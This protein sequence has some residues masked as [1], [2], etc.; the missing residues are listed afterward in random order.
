MYFFVK[1]DVRKANFNTFDA[2]NSIFSHISP[3]FIGVGAPFPHPH[4]SMKAY[5][6]T[7]EE[8]MMT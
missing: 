8:I 1:F 6:S 7:K 5:I 2:K 3:S 4:R